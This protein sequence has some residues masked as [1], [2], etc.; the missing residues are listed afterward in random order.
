MMA[1]CMCV[2]LSLSLSHTHTH[3][4]CLCVCTCA[5]VCECVCVCVCVC[6]LHTGV[7]SSQQPSS[8]SVCDN[9]RLFHSVKGAEITT[10]SSH[11]RTHTTMVRWA[12]VS[13]H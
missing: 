1:S 8:S 11:T 13:S 7:C 6:V 9:C 10:R 4:V 3:S 2:F 12:T 5:C